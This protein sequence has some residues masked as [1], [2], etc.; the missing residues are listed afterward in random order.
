MGPMDSPVT[1]RPMRPDDW[2]AVH[3]IY[4][5]GIATGEATFE[6]EPPH[7]GSVRRRPVT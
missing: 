4:A 1:I 3:A 2:D 6:S 7:L 5:A